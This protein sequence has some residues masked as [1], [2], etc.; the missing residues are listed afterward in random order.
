MDPMTKALVADIHGFVAARGLELVSFATGGDEA[1]DDGD[2]RLGHRHQR[3][4]GRG[5]R[6]RSPV[7]AAVGQPALPDVGVRPIHLEE[8]VFVEEWARATVMVTAVD[9]RP[10]AGQS[11]RAVGVAEPVTV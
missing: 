3:R 11:F 10:A 7:P 1:V 2:Q 5:G 9:A 8:H 4:G 6:R